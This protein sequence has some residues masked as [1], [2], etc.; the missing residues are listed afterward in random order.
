MCQKKPVRN[1]A[2]THKMVPGCI[3]TASCSKQDTAASSICVVENARIPLTSPG[4]PA[5]IPRRCRHTTQYFVPV[6]PSTM[7][8]I[9]LA[10]IWIHDVAFAVAVVSHI[11]WSAGGLSEGNP[12]MPRVCC[13]AKLWESRLKTISQVKSDGKRSTY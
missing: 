5:C 11:M 9:P 2:K 3:K 1:N 10:S 4:D 12:C 7:V 8:A 6:T 13:H